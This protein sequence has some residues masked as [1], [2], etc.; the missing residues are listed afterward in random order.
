MSWR[1]V[2]SKI[3]IKETI[4]SP[5]G[6]KGNLYID[7][8]KKAEILKTFFK[9]VLVG[10]NV[11]TIQ[12]FN[13]RSNTIITEVNFYKEENKKAILITERM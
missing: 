12:D 9:R 3:K 13:I 5:V 6:P 7:D 1:F 8:D 4:P 11:A 2:N 10:E